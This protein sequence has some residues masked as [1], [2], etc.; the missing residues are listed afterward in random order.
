MATYY[1]D[2]DKHS[3]KM[4]WQL[5]EIRHEMQKEKISVQDIN[6]NAELLLKRYPN[7]SFHR[8]RTA[9]R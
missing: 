2:F 6:G 5:H 9:R 1:N 4:M 7:K 3:D 8:M